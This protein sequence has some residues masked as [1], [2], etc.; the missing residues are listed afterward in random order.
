MRTGSYVPFAIRRD[1][2]TARELFDVP[3]EVVVNDEH[4]MV[5]THAVQHIEFTQDLHRRFG[6]GPA[7]VNRDD[8]AEFTLERTSAGKLYGH[9]NI[10]VSPQQIEPWNGALRHIGLVVDPVDR[11]RGAVFQRR[12][13]TGENFLR[14]AHHDMIGHLRTSGSVLAQGPPMNV[15]VPSSLARAR[16]ARASVR[17]ACIALTITRSAQPKSS[18]PTRQMH[19]PPDVGSR[20]GHRAATVI[21]PSGGVMPDSGSIC[22]APS[23]PQNDGGNLGHTSNTLRF[24]PSGG[25]ESRL[26]STDNLGSG[27][28]TSTGAVEVADG[29]LGR[30]FNRG[31]WIE[32]MAPLSRSVRGPVTRL[33]T[34]LARR[35]ADP[36]T[37]GNRQRA[38]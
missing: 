1:P 14:L 8:V 28:G 27:G 20:I 17:C 34:K 37:M 13:N 7:T 21:N 35:L 31:S 19:G 4:F 5:P 22:S 26:G 18:S 36:S 15:R 10:P 24:G 3:D 30:T 29:W 9:R 12:G 32:G 23:K 6:A 16:I 25:K 33:E 2:G 38:N 11:M